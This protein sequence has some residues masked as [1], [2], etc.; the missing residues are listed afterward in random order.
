M[1]TMNTSATECH[2]YQN[3]QISSTQLSLNST[4]KHDI[5]FVTVKVHASQFKNIQLL[6][7]ELKTIYWRSL[8]YRLGVI[9]VTQCR[10]SKDQSHL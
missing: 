4:L 7:L 5:V 8:F 3:Y 9:S 2:F 1:Q 6:R 10:T